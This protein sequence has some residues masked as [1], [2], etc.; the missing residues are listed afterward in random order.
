M[1]KNFTLVVFFNTSVFLAYKNEVA[2]MVCVPPWH[3]L[4]VARDYATQIIFENN[5]TIEFVCYL[6]QHNL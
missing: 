1:F 2:N 5:E 3:I 4:A 6:C